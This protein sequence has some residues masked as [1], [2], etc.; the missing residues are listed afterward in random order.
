MQKVLTIVVPSYNTQAHIDLCLPTMIDKRFIDDIE[1]LLINDGSTDETVNLLKK[2]EERFPNSIRVINKENGGH[3][4]VINRGIR[5]AT[6][7]YF[8]VVDGDDPLI[9]DNLYML[10][11]KLK[12]IDADM[13]F[14]S[15]YTEFIEKKERELCCDYELE[16]GKVY[17]F[18]D[19][20]E[21]ID[22]IPLHAINYKVSILRDNDIHVQEQCFYEDKEYN[23]YPI[24]YIDDVIYYNIPIYVYRIGVPGQSISVEKVVKNRMM[25][26][27]ITKNLCIFYEKCIKKDI[28]FQKQRYLCCA[29]CDVIKNMYGMYL[30]LPF[31]IN[32][33]NL[34]N[35]FASDCKS[36][37]DDLY[38]QSNIGVIKLLRKENMVIYFAA[39][40]GFKIKRKRRGF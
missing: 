40:T 39:Y 25:L 11:E 34:M 27:T 16:S 14:S 7:K 18:D 23:L 17:R 21:K 20:C 8:R 36:W 37:S 30:K 10:I 22:C 19:I 35:N 12:N 32:T 26:E 33:F 4:S 28:S 24:P 5:E 29:I 6:G 13:V 1:I 3:G 9:T 38:K 31:G 15:Y 2:Y